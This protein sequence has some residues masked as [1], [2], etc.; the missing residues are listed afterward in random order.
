LKNYGAEKRTLGAV[1]GRG[2][3][4]HFNSG[5]R[6]IAEWNC[7]RFSTETGRRRGGGASNRAM[8]SPL[9]FYKSQAGNNSDQY[10]FSNHLK[11][12]Q[13]YFKFFFITTADEG[14]PINPDVKTCSSLDR[15]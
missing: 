11:V 4:Y 13:N 1:R 3:M 8:K 9:P 15:C 6:G 7:R 12:F 10:H 14:V 2:E 5:S